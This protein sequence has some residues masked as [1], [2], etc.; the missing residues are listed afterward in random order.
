[1]IV[2]YIYHLSSFFTYL[3]LKF[4][5]ALKLK[6]L[7]SKNVSYFLPKNQ[8]CFLQK[9]Q[10]TAEQLNKK[11]YKEENFSPDV[12]KTE[13]NHL[14]SKDQSKRQLGGTTQISP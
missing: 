13:I 9:N 11:S 3:K 4:V 10:N 7:S 14:C 2:K 1:M 8:K 5:F 12:T 6:L